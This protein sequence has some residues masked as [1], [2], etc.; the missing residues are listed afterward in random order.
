MD[1]SGSRVQ[2]PT[3]RDA[4]AEQIDIAVERCPRFCDDL[5]RKDGEFV[6]DGVRC[7][8]TGACQEATAMKEGTVWRS[9][10]HSTFR[11][12]DVDTEQK[13]RF[14][15]DFLNI[16]LALIIVILN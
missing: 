2:R 9:G 11:A 1:H 13:R 16:L 8:L 12:A 6:E 5:L 3:T 14:Q 10:Y 7:L 15:L 4:D